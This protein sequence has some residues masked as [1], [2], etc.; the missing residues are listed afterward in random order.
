MNSE[1]CFHLISECV[2][3]DSIELVSLCS[4]GLCMSPFTAPPRHRSQPQQPSTALFNLYT[5]G[6]MSDQDLSPQLKRQLF[7]SN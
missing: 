6:F 3:T 1:A 4:V 2:L 7:T 5:P